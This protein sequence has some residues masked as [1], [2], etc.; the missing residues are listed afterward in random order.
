VT[1]SE[2]LSAAEFEAIFAQV[3]NWGRWGAQD[4]GGTLNHLTSSTVTSAVGLARTGRTVSLA[5]D[6]DVLPGA[7]NHKPALHYMTQRSDID[8]G[9]PRVNTDFVGIDFHGK[10]V[11][12]LDALCHCNFRGRLYGGID[13]V[14]VVTSSGSS[15][16]SVLAAAGGIVGRGVLLDVPLIQSVDWLEPGTGVTDADLQAVADSQHVEVRAGDI[17]VVRTGQGRRRTSLGSW[18]SR[19]FSAGLLP[20]AMIWMHAHD[21]AVLGSDGDSDTRPSPVRDVHSPIHALALAAMGM[22]LIDN[23]ALED[24]ADTCIELMT[25]EFLCV[26]APLRIPGGTGSPLNPI[27]I[28]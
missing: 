5:H 14:D 17:V 16:G 10:S 28:F 25:W 13:P 11:T 2:Q 3:S 1:L 22:P 8:A 18:D 15:H 23:L 24:I 27:A 4:Q 12:H 21:V 26:L 6:V 19:D 9:E 7:D 20:S